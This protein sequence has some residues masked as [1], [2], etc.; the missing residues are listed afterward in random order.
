MDLDEYLTKSD[1]TLAAFAEL[2]SAET[3]DRV[4][5]QTVWNWRRK[6]RSP[7]LASALAIVKITGGA[8][9]PSDLVMIKVTA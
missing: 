5:V 7:E 9:Q 3:G 6:I 4:A 1:L 8:V 2:L